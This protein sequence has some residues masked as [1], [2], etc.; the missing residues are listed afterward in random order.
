MK[1]EI[2]I[3]QGQ[4]KVVLTGES[5]FEL[6]LIEKIIDSRVGYK[7]ETTVLSNYSYSTH[8]KHRIEI[9]LIENNKK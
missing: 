8:S 9:S 1:T 6:D 3:K 7:T 4:A 5:E 2:V